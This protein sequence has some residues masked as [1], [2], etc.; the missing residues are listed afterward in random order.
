MICVCGPYPAHLPLVV[1][2][3]CRTDRERVRGI[4]D[5]DCL[6]WQEIKVGLVSRSGLPQVEMPIQKTVAVR[7]RNSVVIVLELVV[8]MRLESIR[9]AEHAVQSDEVR[10]SLRF[11]FLCP[12]IGSCQP[13]RPRGGH[14][15]NVD[16]AL[17]NSQIM[18]IFASA[19]S[20]HGCRYHHAGKCGRHPIVE[21][22]EHHCLSA[23]PAGACDSN[24]L[25]IN[26]CQ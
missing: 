17:P 16:I 4:P 8:E 3:G 21:R 18:T 1:V 5:S 11:Q 24:P 7:P 19:T 22:R 23:T 6:G 14:C 15:S 2:A 9:H 13:Q 10:V 25:R 12:I 26:A 20:L